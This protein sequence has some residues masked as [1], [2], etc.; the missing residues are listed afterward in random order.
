MATPVHRAAL[1]GD[2]EELSRLLSVDEA[3]V[4]VRDERG[5]T[6]I[7]AAAAGT[8]LCA[9]T[10]VTLPVWMRALARVVVVGAV[11]L[12]AS[13]PD[14]H[15]MLACRW[16]RGGRADADR[17][18]RGPGGHGAGRVVLEPQSVVSGSGMK[19]PRPLQCVV[20][21]CQRGG[22]ILSFH[23]LP[24]GGENFEFLTLWSARGGAGRHLSAHGVVHRRHG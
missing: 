20:D 2:L 16:T 19:L 12:C 9:W 15:A 1:R 4:D 11:H 24:L 22:G 10:G 3:L 13:V 14:L 5:V 6:P 21:M 7:M 17:T 8:K 23:N 18:R